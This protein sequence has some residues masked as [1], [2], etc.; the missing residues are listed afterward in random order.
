MGCKESKFR[1]SNASQ[2]T[3]TA[4]VNPIRSNI[5]L[6]VILAVSI[7]NV[8]L[9]GK[10]KF[11]YKKVPTVMAKLSPGDTLEFPVRRPYISILKS[12][13]SNVPWMWWMIFRSRPNKK[14]TWIWINYRPPPNRNIIV[15]PK[16]TAVLAK[17]GTIWT[18]ETGGKPYYPE[19][20][21]GF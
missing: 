19:P 4:V 18:P 9:K 16:G 12:P 2:D 10:G 1:I 3:V 11:Y 6:L 20:D 5:E 15:T 14:P 7:R 21:E 17:E 13:A 8:A